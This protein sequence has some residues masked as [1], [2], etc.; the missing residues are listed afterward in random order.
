MIWTIAQNGLFVV[1]NVSLVIWNDKFLVNNLH[2]HQFPETSY[3]VDLWESS[4]TNTF[5]NFKILKIII[6]LNLFILTTAYLQLLGMISQMILILH[7]LFPEQIS[8]ILYFK[9]LQAQN[10][11]NIN[12]WT[13]HI[14]HIILNLVVYETDHMLYLCLCIVREI[15][16]LWRSAFK[17]LNYWFLYILAGFGMW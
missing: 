3:K 9:F 13:F 1:N 16:S 14:N 11:V 6:A 10:I 2:G 8:Q 4:T 12:V 15:Y 5:D 7:L 17:A